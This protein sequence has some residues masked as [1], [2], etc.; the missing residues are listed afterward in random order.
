[1]TPEE[2]RKAAL[3]YHHDG[4][5][6]KISVVATKPCNTAQDLSLAYTPGVAQP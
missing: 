3:A 1:M 6:G 2:L 4:A 5:P